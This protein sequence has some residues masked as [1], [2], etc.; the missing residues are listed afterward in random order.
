[1]EKRDKAGTAR[2]E[3]VLNCLY[4]KPN[5][6]FRLIC[7][8]WAGG[9]S[10]YFA[11]WGETMCDFL[12]VHCIRLAGRESRFEEPF[13]SDIYQIV[14]E[15]VGALLPILQDKPFAFFGHS[16][17]SYIS[18][19]TALHLKEK[20]NLELM[21]LFVSSMTPPHSKAKIHIPERRELSEEQIQALILSFGGT[22]MDFFNNKELYEQYVTRLEADA[23]IIKNYIFNAPAEPILSCDLTCFVGS[24]DTAED[25][26]AWK[27]LTRGSFDIHVRPGN[28]FYLMETSN[29][30]FIK[31]YISKCLEL[32]ML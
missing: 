26:E 2:N 16:M 1:M 3:K 4:Q 10:T 6:I 28:H 12:E 24:E 23:C 21:H 13:A 17:G 18:F 5:A 32:S 22:H 7:F 20:H 30:T 19:M 31:N 27:E 8:P 9:G 14:D 11:K 15:I 25:V 29:E